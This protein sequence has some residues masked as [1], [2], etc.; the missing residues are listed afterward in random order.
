MLRISV[1]DVVDGQEGGRKN[2][3]NP[4]CVQICGNHDALFTYVD[5]LGYLNTVRVDLK[6]QEIQIYDV[7]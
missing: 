6:K 5:A 7:G 3:P 2:Y 4:V 1:V